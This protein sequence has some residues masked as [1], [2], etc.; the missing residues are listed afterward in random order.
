[1]AYPR[2]NEVVELQEP[3]GGGWNSP[4]AEKY[5]GE[6]IK[7]GTADDAQDMYRLGRTQEFKR[8]F[9]SFSVLGLSSV[10]M[11]T[12]VAFLGSSSFSLINGGLAG[13]VWVYI[14]IW[15][16]TIPVTLSLAEMAS[17]APTSGGQ[18][19]W[20]SEFAP[21]SCQKFLSYVVG[22]L[23][24]TGWQAAIAT[25]AYGSAYVILEMASL[26]YPNYV[27]TAWQ[28]T[29]MTMAITVFSLFFNTIGA[30]HLPLFESLILFLHIF[31][32]F[33]IIIPLWVLAP[34]VGHCV[35]SIERHQELTSTFV[36]TCER[37]LH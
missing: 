25:T 32:F 2:K 36:G 9:R 3:V 5:E 22:W 30:K 13:T 29:L 33:A 28:G 10:I 19:H 7:T 34:K 14:G 12:W 17:M 6:G 11:A 15:I 20:T 18:Y 21:P 16:F 24:A 4:T 35:N 23:S 37:G 31:G 27:A 1:M 26:S 8:N